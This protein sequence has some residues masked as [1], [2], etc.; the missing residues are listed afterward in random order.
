MARILVTETIADGGLDR[1]GFVGGV[2]DTMKSALRLQAPWLEAARAQPREAFDVSQ[3]GE[4][5][6]RRNVC[7]VRAGH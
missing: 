6:V 4:L 7:R 3:R 5:L 1:A 2:A